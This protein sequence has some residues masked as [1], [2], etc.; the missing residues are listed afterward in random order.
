MCIRDRSEGVIVIPATSSKSVTQETQQYAIIN[1]DFDKDSSLNK[2]LLDKSIETEAVFKIPTTG[3]S[4]YY[5]HESE[6]TSYRYIV[7]KQVNEYD[8]WLGNAWILV[9]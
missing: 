4:K 9:K 5:V 1:G 6:V 7:L 3:S 8:R 2:L